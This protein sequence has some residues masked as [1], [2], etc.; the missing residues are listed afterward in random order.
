MENFHDAVRRQE[1]LLSQVERR[2]LQA[3]ARRA[4]GWIHPDHLTALGLCSMLFAGVCYA[5]SRWWALALLLVNVWIAAN[6]LGDS[7]DGT[8]A[9]FR[10]R[11]RPRYGFYVDHMTDSFG[12]LFLIAGLAISG[13]MSERVAVGLLVA[14]LLLSIH[15]YLATCTDGRF[16]LSYAKFSPTEIRLLLMVGNCY[17]YA[18]PVTRVFGPELRFFDV[19]GSVAV[20]CMSAMLL[21]VVARQTVG[22]YRAERLP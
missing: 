18:K 12:A 16:Q 21:V 13:R 11:L 3:L 5:A 1:S 15:S 19:A 4:P 9:R 14:F 6:W 10:G 20:I 8:L 2:V 22:L 7:L 17:A